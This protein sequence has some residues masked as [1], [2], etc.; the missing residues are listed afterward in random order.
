MRRDDPD[1]RIEG[2]GWRDRLTDASENV[3]PWPGDDHLLL[4]DARDHHKARRPWRGALCAH[5]KRHD[6][7]TMEELTATFEW[8]HLRLTKNEIDDL[9]TCARTEELIKLEDPSTGYAQPLSE[10][11][12]RWILTDAGKRYNAPRGAEPI[13]LI[14][15]FWPTTK[16]L[17]G[18]SKLILGG[19]AF[20]AVGVLGLNIKSGS[21]AAELLFIAALWLLAAVV[22]I[23][24]LVNEWALKAMA[25]SWPRL[26]EYRPGTYA[27][28]TYRLPTLGPASLCFTLFVA[29]VVAVCWRCAVHGKLGEPWW[30]GTV[31]AL[32]VLV[33]FVTFGAHQM[34]SMRRDRL[35]GRYRDEGG[36]LRQPEFRDAPPLILAVRE[37]STS[38]SG[39]E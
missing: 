13:A 16:A 3:T 39:H 10:S 36:R 9:V 19:A 11:E 12:R 29:A 1:D 24:G 22:L 31:A 32:T 17:Y 6:G 5:L 38:P 23:G 7:C 20:L 30:P 33:W 4:R 35:R 25:R 28:V 14:E 15:R 8:F 2:P 18:S 26:A 21:L 27:L 34:F 37:P